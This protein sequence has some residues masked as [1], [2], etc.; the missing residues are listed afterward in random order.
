MFWPA[1]TQDDCV[2][3]FL[4]TYSDFV[5]D[6]FFRSIT[7]RFVFWFHLLVIMPSFQILKPL[8][9]L[10]LFSKI[11]PTP[12]NA[13]SFTNFTSKLLI[14]YQLE[15]E[16]NKQ[17]PT[18]NACLVSKQTRELL[19]EKDFFFC[20]CNNPYHIA[21]V[22]SNATLLGKAG[23]KNPKQWTKL[24]L[25]LPIAHTLCQLLWCGIFGNGK[26]SCAHPCWFFF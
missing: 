18:W 3:C 20:F 4:A 21:M 8:M 23:K 14:K 1:V 11:I 26:A 5:L 17:D 6:L 24:L 12:T 22:T 15:M 10:I 2:V 9:G 7:P 25:L 13:M 16:Q 19:F